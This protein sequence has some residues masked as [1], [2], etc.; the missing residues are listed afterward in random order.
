MKQILTLT[1]LAFAPLWAFAQFQLSGDVLFP[2]AV[3]VCNVL[4]ELKTADGQLLAQDLSE[5]DGTFLLADIPAGT[6][7]ELYFSKDDSPLNGTSTFD[8]VLL[9]RRILGIDPPQ[10]YDSWIGDVNA[11]SSTTTLDMVI[12]RKLIL[13]IETTFPVPVWAFDEPS[14]LVPDNKIPVPTFS[15]DT[16][17]EVIGVKR[18]DL[19]A[20]ATQ[21]CQ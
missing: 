16:D 4:V 10:A 2:N 8:L 19:N 12:I 13:Q 1:L 18:A 6:N 14:A 7:Y 21:N 3:P 15:A 9:A 20:S 17:L 11:T 5:E